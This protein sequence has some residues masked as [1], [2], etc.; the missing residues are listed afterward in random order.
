MTIKY[1]IELLRRDRMN[2]A[3]VLLIFG[4]IIYLGGAT[5]VLLFEL[6]DSHVATITTSIFVGMIVVIY[7]IVGVA[8]A[9][10]RLLQIEKQDAEIRTL[11]EKY[12]KSRNLLETID[13]QIR[14]EI[15][16]WIHG[17]LQ[18]KLVKLAKDVRNSKSEELE[19]IAQRID[20]INEHEVRDY[21]HKLFPPALLVSLEVGL[22]SLLENRAELVL[23]VRFTNAA[24]LRYSILNQGSEVSLSENSARLSVGRNLGYAI[25]RMIEEA[26]ANSEKKFGT[27]EISVHVGL[28][29]DLLVISVRDNGEPLA[30]KFEFGLG[31]SVIEAFSQKYE[32]TMSLHNVTGGVELLVKIPY[33]PT[34]FNEQIERSKS[35]DR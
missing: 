35:K 2:W 7:A 25:Y 12:L 30:S 9:S 11:F 24:D 28:E 14:E 5:M 15:G 26:V 34:S 4:L 16:S 13:N 18:P 32:G 3:L 19:Q 8:R 6:D 27:T 22:E 17:T 10:A 21:A 1:L 33:T 23:D 29:N 31:L 20:E